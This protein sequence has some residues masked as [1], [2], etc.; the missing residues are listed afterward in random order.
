MGTL[1]LFV[2]NLEHWFLGLVE[3][4]GALDLAGLGWSLGK[5]IPGKFPRDADASGLGSTP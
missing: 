3:R 2:G 4:E 5:C 1:A